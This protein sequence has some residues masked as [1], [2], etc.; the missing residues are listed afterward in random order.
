MTTDVVST[1]E[2]VSQLVTDVWNEGQIEELD[3]LLATDFVGHG[4]GPENLDRD[5]YEEFV[6]EHREIFPDLEFVLEDV[7]GEDDRVA[8][9]WTRSGT[10]EKPVMGVE[11]TGNR[12]SVSG[13]TIYRILEG[14]IVEAWNIRDTVAM[15]KQLGLF[16]DQF[17]GESSAQ[18]EP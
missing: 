11:P 7:I 1:K 2:R 10:Q 13:M 4:F 8:A 15:L 16:P 9:R 18:S 5:G 17:Q 6:I 3:E 14:T 12:I